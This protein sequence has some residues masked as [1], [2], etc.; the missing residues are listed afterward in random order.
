SAMETVLEVNREFG[1]RLI[2]ISRSDS[3]LR[4]HFPLET[5]VMRRVLQEYGVKRVFYGH[6]HGGGCQYAVNG[7]YL[8]MEFRMV[9]GDHLKFMP[10]RIENREETAKSEE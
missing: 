8:D 3:C 4:G 5:D 7:T 9:S 2:F 10:Y 1:Y 6:I